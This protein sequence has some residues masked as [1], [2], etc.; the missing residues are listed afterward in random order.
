[1]F[2]YPGY[3]CQSHD[4]EQHCVVL[5]LLTVKKK[6]IKVSKIYNF[7]RLI[8]IVSLLKGILMYFEFDSKVKH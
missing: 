1:M 4:N 5:S 2:W 3:R 6:V 7:K 8:V